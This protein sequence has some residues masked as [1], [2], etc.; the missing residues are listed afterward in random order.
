MLW[1]ACAL[2]NA[3]GVILGP[4]SPFLA[5]RGSPNLNSCP[6]HKLGVPG[7]YSRQEG[8]DSQDELRLSLCERQSATLLVDDIA[9]DF[10]TYSSSSPTSGC[11]P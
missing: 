6:V 4:P 5:G 1:T 11:C 7:N 8:S 2:G 9:T 3:S 10:L